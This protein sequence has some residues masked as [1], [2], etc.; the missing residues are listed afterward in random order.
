M[1]PCPMASDLS[2]MD[3]GAMRELTCLVQ[4]SWRLR[5]RVLRLCRW[6]VNVCVCVAGT[7]IPRLSLSVLLEIVFD[8]ISVF[9]AM[10]GNFRRMAAGQGGLV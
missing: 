1:C 9:P 2:P 3:S 8:R 10:Y 7:G 5:F 6:C 4:W